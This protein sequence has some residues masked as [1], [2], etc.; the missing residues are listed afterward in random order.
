MIM[1]WRCIGVCG[2]DVLLCVVFDCV[3][4]MY[5]YACVVVMYWCMLIVEMYKCL[6]SLCLKHI[7]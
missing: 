2:G 3:V 4:V 1:L 5:W 6:L 7:I